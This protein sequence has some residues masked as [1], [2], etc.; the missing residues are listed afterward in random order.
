MIRLD[1]MLKRLGAGQA[2]AR[3]A[4]PPAALRPLLRR[5]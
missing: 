1:F 5:Y 2:Q 4:G 3:P